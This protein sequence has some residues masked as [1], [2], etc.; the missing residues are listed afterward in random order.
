MQTVANE[1]LSQ[2]IEALQAIYMVIHAPDY[3]EV[4]EG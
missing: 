2:E 3:A 1:E 4:V